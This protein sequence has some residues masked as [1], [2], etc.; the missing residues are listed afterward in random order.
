VGDINT[1]IGG[2]IVIVPSSGGS[3]TGYEIF[4]ITGAEGFE[5]SNFKPWTNWLKDYSV[6]PELHSD[7]SEFLAAQPNAIY[8]SDAFRV[9]IDDGAITD[10]KTYLNGSWSNDF[11][12]PLAPTELLNLITSQN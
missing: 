1:D 6:A 3:S 4:G 7:I 2:G 10:L 5:P 9:L 8:S 11:S 12:I